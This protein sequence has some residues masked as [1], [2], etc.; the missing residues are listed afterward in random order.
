MI[1]MAS[2]TQVHGL[3]RLFQWT[4]KLGLVIGQSSLVI[5]DSRSVSGRIPSKMVLLDSVER[6]VGAGQTQWGMTTVQVI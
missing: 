3:S 1:G 6:D 4:S 2:S 5:P